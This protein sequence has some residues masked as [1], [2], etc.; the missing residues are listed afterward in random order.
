MCVSAAA[1]IMCAIE[2]ACSLG[3]EPYV[4]R[5]YLLLG[6]FVTVPAEF[7]L[8]CAAAAASGCMLRCQS[9]AAGMSRAIVGKITL[10]REFLP[11]F[12]CQR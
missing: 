2:G 12:S 8:V 9:A 1:G 4:L 7:L 11:V 3:G 6:G 5:K 10:G